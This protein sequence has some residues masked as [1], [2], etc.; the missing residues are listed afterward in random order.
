MH[1]WTIKYFLPLFLSLF[2]FVTPSSAWFSKAK[3]IEFTITNN[4]HIYINAK[5]KG[6]FTEG[7][8]EAINSG[9]P[10]TFKYYL[11]LKKQHLFWFDKKIVK[12][13]IQHRVEYDTLKKEYRVTIDNGIS[14]QVKISRNEEE[15]KK[16]MASIDSLRF[17]P[18]QKID[19][20]KKY[21]IRLKAEM[22]CIKMPFPL[23]YLLSYISFWDFDTPWVSLRIP[24][25]S[26]N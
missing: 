1:N 14:S 20:I 3:I 9:I 4:N 21:Q 10:T 24:P 11:E 15:M 6:A 16:W 12:K 13:L 8:T 18:S 17:L 26:T 25:K 22:K 19:P 5:V 7:I 2:F 23:N